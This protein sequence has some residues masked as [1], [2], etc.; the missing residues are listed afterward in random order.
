[1]KTL[2]HIT[3]T[4]VLVLLFTANSNAQ[5]FEISK[6]NAKH[7][8]IVT[9]IES[10][11]DEKNAAQ[12]LKTYLDTI[13]NS[14]FRIETSKTSK[15]FISLDTDSTIH[16]DAFEIQIGIRSINITGGSR[17]GCTYAV[18]ELLER[19][20]G[21]MYLSP[22]Y[23]IVPKQEKVK[24]VPYSFG[25][26]PKNDVRIINLYFD[27]S[28]EYRDWLRLNSIEEVYP[29]GYFVHTFHR[30]IPWETYFEKQP[31][32]FALINGKRSI[33]QLCMSNPEVRDLIAEKLRTEMALQPEKVKWSVSQNDNFSY[34]QCEK[35]KHIMEEEGS[36]AGPI[37]HLVNDIAA[38]FPDKIISTLAD[39]KSVV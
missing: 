21:C 6:K 19:C 29:E 30:L 22:D 39:R 9:P 28:Q 37:I 35:C 18:I 38:R 32:Y 20:F 1:M 34:C 12:L 2:L 16:P 8:A 17:K 13:F 33:D 31:E 11:P 3:Q 23:K 27:E 24:L 36:P 5:Y 26:I 7:L 4:L 14:R 25:E 15:R 10:T